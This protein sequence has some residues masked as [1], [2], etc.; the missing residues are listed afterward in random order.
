MFRGSGFRDSRFTSQIK[1]S[2]VQGSG[3]VKVN[4]K[5][6][7]ERFTLL[8]RVP[9]GKFNKVNSE[10]V[11]AYDNKMLKGILDYADKCGIFL[12]IGVLLLTVAYIF[13]IR[14]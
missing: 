4:K 11:N 10:P 9:F 7:P 12:L 1:G 2:E 13:L 8:N 5:S 14:E 6:N 3:L